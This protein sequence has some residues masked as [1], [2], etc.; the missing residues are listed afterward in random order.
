M[1]SIVRGWLR[2]A[3]A[4]GLVAA[5]APAVALGQRPRGGGLGGKR[6]MR[7]AEKLERRGMR[8]DAERSPRRPLNR[9]AVIARGLRAVNLSR[10]QQ[11]AVREIRDRNDARMREFGRQML[12]GRR[13]VDELLFAETPATESA[14]TSGREISRLAGERVKARTLI[15]L[16]VFRVLTPEQRAM[17]RRMR[18]TNRDQRSEAPDARPGPGPATGA[19]PDVPGGDD[20]TALEEDLEP[21]VEPAG[22]GPDRRKARAPRGGAGGLLARMSLAPD[23]QQRFRQLRRQQGPRLRSLAV[24]LRR[25]QIAVDDALLADSVD[26]DLV[27]R[28]AEQLGQLE[29]DRE[30]ARFE[31]ELAIRQILTPD[32]AARMREMRAGPRP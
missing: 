25:T 20:D 18:D 1:R 13:H 7:R 23:Q 10:D 12:D 29:A 8:P 15:E 26:A 31:T 9:G 6:E 21:D 30:M 17:M 2:G 19:P 5:L 14:R 32:Q 28:L 4:L 11:R 22:P 16:E 24:Q 3:L 27:R